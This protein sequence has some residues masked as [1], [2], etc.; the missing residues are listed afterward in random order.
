MSRFIVISMLL[1][2]LLGQ[3]GT[4][5]AAAADLAAAPAGYTFC[6][7]ANH[8]CSFNGTGGVAFG[9]NGHFKYKVAVKKIACNVSVFGD[10]LPGVKKACYYQIVPQPGRRQA[11]Y[12]TSY[13]YNDNDDG[14]GHY[15]TAVI[16]YP[17]EHHPI[18]T[19][20]LGTYAD[21]ITFATDEN[22]IPPHTMIYVLHLQKYFFMEDGCSE[23]STDWKNGHTWRTDLF[24]G[25]N[26]ALQ[27]EPALDN[28]ESRITRHA[29][30]YIHAGPGFPVDVTPLFANGACT[31]RMH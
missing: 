4:P 28:C 13:G 19:E 14:N 16:A 30:M 3:A 2:V 10:P 11:T 31:A 26:T 15:G 24:M 20:G 7:N 29:V 5:P 25:G 17:D 8:T 27:P 6:A 21:P 18:A 12:F 22:E 23:C 1:I 9:A